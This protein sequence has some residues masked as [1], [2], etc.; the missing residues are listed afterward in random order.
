VTRRDWT[1]A[2]EH[3]SAHGIH[4]YVTDETGRVWEV[5][6]RP[7]YVPI[8]VFGVT[9]LQGWEWL[10]DGRKQREFGE[11]MSRDDAWERALRYI[12][13]AGE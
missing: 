13:A 3:N 6:V 2:E 11:P 8:T 10:V 7:I 5:L 4:A 9:L 12:A 1:I